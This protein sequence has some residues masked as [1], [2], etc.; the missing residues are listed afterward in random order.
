MTR[1][2][3]YNEL[4]QHDWTFMYSDDHSMYT[5]GRQNIERL[6]A[7]A[8]Q[9]PELEELFNAYSKWY[10]NRMDGSLEKPTVES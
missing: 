9:S 4:E 6:T 3:F 2:E 10:W 1:E 5:R 7:I 8:S